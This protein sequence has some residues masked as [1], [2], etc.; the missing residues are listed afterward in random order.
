M[1]APHPDRILADLKATNRGK[2][3]HNNLEKL[4]AVCLDISRTTRDFSTKAVGLLSQSKGGPTYNTLSSPGGKHFRALVSA[5]AAWEGVVTK[6]PKAPVAIESSD[7]Q[8]LTQ[9]N[10]MALRAKIAIRLAELR[11]LRR[12]VTQLKAHANVTIEVRS[13]Q[14]VPS[15]QPQPAA[16]GAVDLL[17]TERRAIET[18][19]DPAWLARHGWRLGPE[20]SVL[21]ERGDPRPV[22]PVGFLTGLQRLL[23]HPDAHL[24]QP[25][26]PLLKQP[27][28]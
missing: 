5:W 11:R 7:E 27:T 12:E 2:R 8:D 16:S 6:R 4:H 24:P 14:D 9:I 21:R 22:F 20:G 26:V 15:P 10:N 13:Q 18:V 3:V 1:K 23:G 28:P 19:V 17:P 25:P